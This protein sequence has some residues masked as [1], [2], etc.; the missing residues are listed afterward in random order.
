MPILPKDHLYASSV[1]HPENYSMSGYYIQ[2][3]CQCNPTAGSRVDA[4]L[5]ILPGVGSDEHPV[6][7]EAAA[8]S[9]A[10]VGDPNEAAW[11]CYECPSCLCKLEQWM[12]MP[13]YA[14]A[15]MLCMARLVSASCSALAFP[16]FASSFLARGTRKSAKVLCWA[17][18]CFFLNRQL[19]WATSCTQLRKAQ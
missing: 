14:L 6:E 11:I 5:D 9:C 12:Q 2:G 7:A 18:T 8:P 17:T 10:G 13:D 4:V 3:Q 16:A 19:R 15:N 1:I